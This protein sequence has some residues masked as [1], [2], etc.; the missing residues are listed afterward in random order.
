MARIPDAGRFGGCDTPEIGERL[1]EGGFNALITMGWHLK[2]YLQ[3]LWAAKRLGIPVIVRGDSQLATPRGRL[4]RMAKAAVYPRLIRSFEAALYVGQRNREYFEHYGYPAERLF[5][6][7]HCIETDRFADLATPAAREDHR[8][9][10]GI[11]AETRAILF[12]G[13]LVPFKR[14]TQVV[15]A[16]ARLRANGMSAHVMIAGSGI[17]ESEL[18]ERAASLNV[19]IHLL[20]FQNQS[21]MP[22]AYAA[23]DV[24]VL[25]S[26]GAE[27]WGLT[28]NE[29]LACGTPIVVSNEVGCAPDLAGDGTAG[30]VFRGGDVDACATALGRILANPPSAAALLAKSNE[31]SMRKAI[32]GI[33]KATAWAASS[34]VGR[35]GS[36]G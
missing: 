10:M 18:V 21:M 23:A 26:T 31:H 36:D 29:A 22:A 19:P 28:C 2:T 33:I 13:K 9:R 3:G 17:L 32:D 8:T 16:V 35:P 27:T 14:P 6:S 12:A 30:A 25:P 4:K 15:E 24:L 5:H 20:G 11:D 1:G 34:R 7:P